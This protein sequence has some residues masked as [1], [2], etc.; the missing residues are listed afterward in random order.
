MIRKFIGKVL[1]KKQA[2]K[3][4]EKTIRFKTEKAPIAKWLDISVLR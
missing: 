3:K 2:E 4:G 1:G